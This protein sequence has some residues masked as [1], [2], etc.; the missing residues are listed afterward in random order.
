MT[1]GNFFIYINENRTQTL[2]LNQRS[3][4]NRHRNIVL[5]SLNKGNE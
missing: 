3:P 1:G 2:K 5:E 4:E